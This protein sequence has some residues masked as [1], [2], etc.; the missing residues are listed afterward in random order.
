VLAIQEMTVN[1]AF[2]PGER[3]YNADYTD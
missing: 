1:I 2:V 3:K